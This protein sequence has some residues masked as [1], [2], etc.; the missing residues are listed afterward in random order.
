MWND[1]VEERRTQ[2][3]MVDFH[4]PLNSLELKTW[5]MSPEMK[6]ECWIT[7]LQGNARRA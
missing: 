6:R 3:D 5:W 7:V 2:G 4:V 1:V